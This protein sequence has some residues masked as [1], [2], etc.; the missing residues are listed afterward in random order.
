M[1]M[2][3][4]ESDIYFGADVGKQ[5]AE[6]AGKKCFLACRRG[7]NFFYPMFLSSKCSDFCGEIKHGRKHK[8]I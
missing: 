6:G 2:A 3:S 1:G 5:G 8:K 4:G 7:K